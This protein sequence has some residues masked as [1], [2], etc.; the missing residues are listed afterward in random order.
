MRS[1]SQIRMPDRGKIYS[2][3]EGNSA[4]FEEP[5]KQYLESI[6]FPSPES[7]RKP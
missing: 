7:G 6:K 3:N 4:Y 1:A 2:F 5:V